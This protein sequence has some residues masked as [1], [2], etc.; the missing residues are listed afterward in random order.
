MQYQTRYYILINGSNKG[1]KGNN[2]NIFRSL[3]C[4]EKY[5][6]ATDELKDHISKIS[7]NILAL[8]ESN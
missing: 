6:A 1:R 8:S 5:K 4:L 7:L 3:S 2:E